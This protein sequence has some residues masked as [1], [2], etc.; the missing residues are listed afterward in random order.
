MFA[1]MHYYFSIPCT[2]NSA[3]FTN[4]DCSSLDHCLIHSPEKHNS[5]AATSAVPGTH[6]VTQRE[7]FL[8]VN[9]V[10]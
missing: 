6:T 1:G 2:L 10:N 9:N 5:P 4:S 7:T 8:N 3:C